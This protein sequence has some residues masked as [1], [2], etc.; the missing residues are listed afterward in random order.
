[1]GTNIFDD[2]TEDVTLPQPT[3][4]FLS[5]F[6]QIVVGDPAEN[7]CLWRDQTIR[8]ENGAWLGWTVKAKSCGTGTKGFWK[9][10]WTPNDV[11]RHVEQSNNGKHHCIW[12]YDGA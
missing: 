6:G 12:Q 4:K 10:I 9:S 2:T 5:N 7:M 11:T 8:A 1:M 3:Y